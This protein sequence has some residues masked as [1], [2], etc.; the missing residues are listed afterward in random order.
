LSGKALELAAQVLLVAAIPR[1][2]GPSDY[3]VFA[4][5]LA[6]VTLGSQAM[7]V[8]GPTLMSRFV[9][10]V[11]LPEQMP[12]ARALFLRL[13]RWRILALG[14]AILGTAV[15][16][17]AAPSTF[18]PTITFLVAG[19][20][21]LDVVATL[22]FQAALALG[23][24]TAW[25][26]RFGTQN[27]L[28][29]AA[30]LAGHALAGVEGAVA[31]VALASGAALAWSA[32]LIGRPLVQAAGGASLPAG[33]LRFGAVQAVGNAFVQ[34]V[35]RGTIVAVALLAGSGVQ[36]GFSALAVGVALAGTYA[37]WQLFTV[38]LPGLV[39]A[40]REEPDVSLAE[41]SLWR[42]GSI[43]LAGALA[44]ALA[45]VSLLQWVMPIIFGERFEGAQGATAVA[46][47]VLPLAPLTAIAT[48]TAA[49]RLRPGLRAW[50]TGAGA[51]AFAATAAPAIPAWGATGG[52]V[53]LLAGTAVTVLASAVAFPTAFEGRLLAAAL[54]GSAA[55]L[56]LALIT[57]AL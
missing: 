57:G 13:A 17:A 45:G 5:A 7:S 9:P 28:L 11:S 26:F 2:L 42:L 32:G 6:V 36:T 20:L 8:G 35:H 10:A 12:L 47:A 50:T 24:T 54:A 53:A 31:G 30:A 40:T 46:L 18:P 52:S 34:I 39:R 1:V 38:Q 48:Q 15:L 16:V 29:V 49:L 56:G 4:L 3:G 41:Q 27:V 19:A 55:V 21:V 25:S 23:R 44:I 14:P 51:L 43:S 33:A 22:A 37:V